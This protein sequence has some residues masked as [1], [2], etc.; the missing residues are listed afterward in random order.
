MNNQGK[1]VVI[2]GGNK[3]IGRA[4]AEAF[5]AENATLYLCA[6]NAETL[7]E[8]AS[9]LQQ[10]FPGCKVFTK[11]T[12]LLIKQ[13]VIDFGNWVIEKGTPDIVINNAGF[14]VPGSTFNEPDGILEKMIGINLY[15]AYHL[16]RTV[17]PPMINK[18]SG[19]IFN[20]CSIASLKA[21]S[22]GGSYGISKFALLGLSK[23]LR[24]ELKPHGIK[25]TVVQPGAVL[26][27][28]WGDFDNS[29][30]RIMETGDIVKMILAATTLSI[31]GTVE[32][33]VIRPQLGDL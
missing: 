13:N 8:T 12:D 11:A 30:H 31:G 25:V 22:N 33:I 29:E 21:Y 20:I 4:L 24:E 27:D 2:T 26:T 9:F 7:D 32:E 3:G 28:S 5:A 18:K 23:N 6:R 19:H 1:H 17:L 16:T 15:S 10:K 14:F